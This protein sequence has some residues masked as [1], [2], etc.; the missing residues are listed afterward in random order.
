MRT[1][2]KSSIFN[3]FASDKEDALLHGHS[4]TAHPVECQVAIKSITTSGEWLFT[5]TGLLSGVIG[6]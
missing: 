5:V 3:A 6:E 1:V 2:A 4:Y